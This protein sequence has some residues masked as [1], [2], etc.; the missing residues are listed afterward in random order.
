VVIAFKISSQFF[1]QL[2]AKPKTIT[3]YT[4]SKLQV[5]AKNSDSFVAVFAPVMFGGVTTLVFIFQ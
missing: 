3:T 1:S 2:E 5:I 4:L